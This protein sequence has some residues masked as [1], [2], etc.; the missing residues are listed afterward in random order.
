MFHCLL[1]VAMSDGSAEPPLKRSRTEDF[2]AA[3]FNVEKPKPP[4]PLLRVK[5][6]GTTPRSVSSG[7]TSPVSPFPKSPLVTAPPL[8]NMIVKS[9]P[10]L[11][12]TPPTFPPT[13]AA[14]APAPNRA[15]RWGELLA[16]AFMEAHSPTEDADKIREL[17]KKTAAAI[18]GDANEAMLRF[19]TLKFALQDSKNAKLRADLLEGQLAPEVFATLRE[20]ELAN[21]EQRRKREEE[22]LERN[23]SKDLN[24]LAKALSS[25]STLFPC[26]RCGARDCT[27]VQRQTRSG[28]EP[29]T[30]CCTCNKCGRVWRKY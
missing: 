6:A 2:S 27:W 7:S 17:M 4:T 23:K 16:T 12:S 20:Q 29:M 19:R 10:L 3:T 25:T 15:V 22:F 1:F 28:D 9:A 21:P 13:V 18:P 5:S 14:A 26:P 8:S 24:E 30:V 11:L